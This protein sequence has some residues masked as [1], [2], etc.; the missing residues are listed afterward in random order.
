MM[1]MRVLVSGSNGFVGAALCRAL[2]R[3]GCNPIC[4]VRSASGDGAEFVV[5]EVD[6]HT[7]WCAALADCKTVVHLAARVHVMRDMEI[8]PLAAF[9]QV[10]VEGTL[11]L[12]RQAAASG[13]RR[14]IFLSSIKVNGEETAVSHSKHLSDGIMKSFREDDVPDPHDAYAVSKWEAEQGLL[15]IALETGME[16]VIIRPPLVYGPGVRANFLV[17]MCWLQKRFPLPMGAI[18]NKRSLVAIDNLLDLILTCI[19]HPAAAN[20]VFLAGD[21]E[22]L[23]TTELLRRLGLA[24]GRPA[25]L[26][27]VPVVLL[28]IGAALLGRKDIA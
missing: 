8:D 24:M 22:D 10:N 14:F 4:A 19:H 2:V 23:S 28:K 6:G 17:M 25:R 15:K 12:A 21:G 3:V 27:P 1:V 16:V 13:V 20:Q 26:L 7:N 11:N 9:R 18:H 5:G